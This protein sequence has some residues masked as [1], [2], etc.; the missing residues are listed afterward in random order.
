ME[1]EWFFFKRF[2]QNPYRKR[3]EHVEFRPSRSTEHHEKWKK[4]R[5]EQQRLEENHLEMAIKPLLKTSDSS[6][7]DSG[8]DEG[9]VVELG[10]PLLPPNATSNPAPTIQSFGLTDRVP[11]EQPGADSRYESR[12]QISPLPAASILQRRTSPTAT[13]ERPNTVSEHQETESLLSRLIQQRE[14]QHTAPDPSITHCL[15]NSIISRKRRSAACSPDQPP[16]TSAPPPND[17]FSSSPSRHAD[18]DETSPRTEF[19]PSVPAPLISESEMQSPLCASL[20]DAPFFNYSQSPADASA[21][22]APPQPQPA[23]PGRASS[24]SYLQVQRPA[25]ILFGDEV[26]LRKDQYGTYHVVGEGDGGVQAGHSGEGS[27]GMHR[28]TSWLDGGRE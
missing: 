16:I 13:I 28:G 17:Q 9:Y 20:P 19:R 12:Q 1:K 23:R 21:Y 6:Q 8:N 24:V 4:M 26:R 5:T 25:T 7:L 27:T 2:Y 15:R 11:S 10:T 14:G 18:G 3:Y 22:P